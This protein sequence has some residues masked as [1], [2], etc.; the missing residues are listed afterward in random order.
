MGELPA[1]LHLDPGATASG[2]TV[3][4]KVENVP[5]C[6]VDESVRCTLRVVEVDDEGEDAVRLAEF[7]VDVVAD[8]EGFAFANAE[9]VLAPKVRVIELRSC[10]LRPI[11]VT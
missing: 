7:L 2:G 5:Q 1:S 10:E 11:R 3:I 9:R 8:G 4:V 6:V